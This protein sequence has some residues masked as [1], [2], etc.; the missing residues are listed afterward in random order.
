MLN[1]AHDFMSRAAYNLA[2][3]KDYCFSETEGSYDLRITRAVR[4]TCDDFC[5]F[6]SGGRIQGDAGHRIGGTCKM[7]IY[8][9]YQ[10]Y[11]EPF[12]S[13]TFNVND[14]CQSHLDSES[15]TTTYGTFICE[16]CCTP[17]HSGALK[18]VTA[19]MWIYT[20]LA[21]SMLYVKVT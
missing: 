13:R 17:P 5:T 21:L 14:G 11:G 19:N 1:Q 18:G 6:N 4:F 2:P 3:K 7:E 9:S 15:N 10:C 20:L 8:L 12:Y 16:N